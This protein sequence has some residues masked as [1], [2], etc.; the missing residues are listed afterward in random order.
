[1]VVPLRDGITTGFLLRIQAARTEPHVSWYLP[2]ESSGPETSVQRRLSELCHYRRQVE[3]AGIEG[4][5]S[6][7]GP[8]RQKSNLQKQRQVFV[9]SIGQGLVIFVVG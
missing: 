9:A 4:H 6:W 7:L 8:E 2:G 3:L 5:V 1:M